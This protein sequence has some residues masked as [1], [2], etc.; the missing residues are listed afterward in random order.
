MSALAMRSHAQR[1][2]SLKPAPRVPSESG[3]VP[4]NGHALRFAASPAASSREGESR[5]FP[6]SLVSAL[7]ASCRGPSPRCEPCLPTVPQPPSRRT[8]P[9]LGLPGD[10]GSRA[11]LPRGVAPRRSGPVW[12]LRRARGGHPSHGLALWT[13]SHPHAPQ[14]PGA[15][16]RA[17]VFELRLSQTLYLKNGVLTTIA[18]LT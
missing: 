4:A 18:R 3:G 13:H 5:S 8:P 16:V 15:P 6:G 17:A 7:A 10:S 9:A 2:L 1:R 11:A 12:L 14:G